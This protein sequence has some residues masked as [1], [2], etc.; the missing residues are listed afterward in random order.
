MYEIGGLAALS[1]YNVYAKY[2]SNKSKKEEFQKKIRLENRLLSRAYRHHK[3]QIEEMNVEYSTIVLHKSNLLRQE[4]LYKRQ[5]L[6]YNLIKSGLSINSNDSVSSLIRAQA[7]RDEI[8]ARQYEIEQFYHRPKFK[9]DKEGLDIS[10]AAGK[11]KIEEIN[12]SL[13]YAK[14]SAFIQGGVG[15]MDIFN[16][17]GW[18]E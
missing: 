1:A 16:K 10:V 11:D 4:Q 17:A 9:I 12:N 18:M 2:R 6:S 3:A 8:Q 13:P 7:H 15:L 14:A 5:S